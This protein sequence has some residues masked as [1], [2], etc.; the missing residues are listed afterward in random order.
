[1]LRLD[2]ATFDKFNSLFAFFPARDLC[3]ATP[4]C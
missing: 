4:V 3:I 1:M 2:T